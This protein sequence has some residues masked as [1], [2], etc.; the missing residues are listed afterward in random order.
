MKIRAGLVAV[1]LL[2]TTLPCLIAAET[3]VSQSTPG[4]VAPPYRFRTSVA[5]N[6]RGY[7]VAWA[8]TADENSDV[9]SIYIRVLGADGVPLRPSPTLLGSGREP[10]AVWNG[11]EYLV[12]WGITT[13]TTSALP[14][15]SVV[16]TRLRE[17][18][19]LIDRQP[20]TLVNEVNP[21]SYL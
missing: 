18:G 14:T 16:G 2:L 19:S 5:T 10:R 3:Q 8:A 1:L 13:R 12:V 6:G 20:V 7:V 21:F 9:R 4:D 15:P 17:D 11:R